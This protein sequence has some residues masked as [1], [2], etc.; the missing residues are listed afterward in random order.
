MV[1]K[2]LTNKITFLAEAYGLPLTL[3]KLVA[4]QSVFETNNF[5][6]KAF[7]ENNNGFGYKYVKGA[8]LQK[9]KGRTSTEFDNY[10]AYDSFDKSIREIVM[11]IY[12]RRNEGKFPDLITITSAEQ[13][14][15][16]L[17]GC[18]YFGGPLKDYIKGVDKYF[19]QL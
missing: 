3:S 4:A 17:K 12:R 19:N 16:L 14:A 18:S 11:W 2:F 13:Y 10:A 7:I 8:F 6:S 5:R 9:G 1:N 15:T